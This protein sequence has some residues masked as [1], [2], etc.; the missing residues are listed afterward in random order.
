MGL[1]MEF[2]KKKKI[3][4]LSNQP[5]WKGALDWKM[6]LKQLATT[7]NEKIREVTIIFNPLL[8]LFHLVEDLPHKGLL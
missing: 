4:I 8:I 7:T 1:I 5:R 6:L 3:E 2:K